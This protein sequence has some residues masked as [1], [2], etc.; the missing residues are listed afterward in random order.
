MKEGMIEGMPEG[1]KEGRTK[2]G[3]R[4]EGGIVYDIG[5]N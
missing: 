1:R 3:R 5:V 4:R 2:E